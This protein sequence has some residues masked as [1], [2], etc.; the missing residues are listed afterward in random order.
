MV[1]K[2][3]DVK[4]VTDPYKEALQKLENNISGFCSQ[5]NITHL[6]IKA[7]SGYHNCL[8]CQLEEGNGQILLNIQKVF[9]SHITQTFVLKPKS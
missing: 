4:A 9:Y 5:Q 7:K 8:A 3:K 1:K 6:G 2:L